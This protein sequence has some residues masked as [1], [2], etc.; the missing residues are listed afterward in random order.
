[1]QL[2]ALAGKD[3]RVDRLRQERVAESEAGGRLHGDNDTV[4]DRQAQ[5]LPD[6][7][8]GERRRRQEQ[9]VPDVAPSGGREPQQALSRTVEPCDALEQQVEQATRE[10]VASD[11][12]RGQGFFREEGVALG[13]VD[14]RVAERRRRGRTSVRREQRRQLLARERS[15][16]EQ[17]RRGRAPGPPS[18]SRLMRSADSSSAR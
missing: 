13:A 8:L 5:R 12:G 14:D 4:L 7:A 18:A 9:R 15:Q 3:R 16:L 2:L 10:L 11:L 1:M 6:G 17:E